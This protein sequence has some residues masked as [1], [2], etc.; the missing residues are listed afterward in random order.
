MIRLLRSGPT[1]RA[2]GVLPSSRTG[3]LA[4]AVAVIAGVG[5]AGCGSSS[6]G[7]ASTSAPV[8]TK[9]EF[10]AKA[11]VICAK[12]DPTLSA[13]GAKLEAQPPKAEIAAIVKGTYVPSIQAQ[14]SGIR[15]L[16]VPAG[17]QSSVARLLA[18]AQADLNKIESNPA[19]IATDVFRDFANVAHPYGLT[20]CAPTS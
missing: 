7:K 18:L 11:N 15:A 12:A 16:G 1:L 3:G 13:A 14:I 6:T 17:E 9:A 20:A 4:I 8:I 10:V 19:L 2:N 5:M